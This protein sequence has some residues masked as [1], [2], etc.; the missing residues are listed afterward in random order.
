[1]EDL[2]KSQIT[3]IDCPACHGTGYAKEEIGTSYRHIICKWCSGIGGVTKQIF[4][5]FFRVN[6]N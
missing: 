1:M 5:S 3:L 4:E 2:K 6:K